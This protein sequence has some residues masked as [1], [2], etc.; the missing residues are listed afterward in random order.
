LMLMA[1]M[2]RVVDLIRHWHC[3]PLKPI[4]DLGIVNSTLQLETLLRLVSVTPLTATSS[5][6]GI[7]A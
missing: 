5:R 4:I 3:L 1:R 6:R 2:G 7:P